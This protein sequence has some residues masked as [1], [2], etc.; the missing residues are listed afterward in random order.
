MLKTAATKIYWK[1]DTRNN[2]EFSK[3]VASSLSSLEFGSLATG[4]AY[5]CTYNYLSQRQ[6]SVTDLRWRG[7][8]P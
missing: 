4:G 5:L 2:A 7:S 6:L 1:H 3:L 8:S